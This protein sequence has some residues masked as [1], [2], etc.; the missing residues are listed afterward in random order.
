MP[1]RML[2][3]RP[4]SV[5][6]PGVRS[7]A[8]RSA[9]ATDTSS[10]STSSWFSRPARTPSKTSAQTGT[11]SG[12]ATHEPS[13]PARRL[14]G[15]SSRTLANA[16]SLT[17]GS[18]RLGMNAAIPPIANAPRR[19]QVRTIRSAYAFIIGAAIVTALRSGRVKDG[20]ASRKFLM[21]LNR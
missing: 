12:C 2:P 18:R 9:A 15:L 20:P 19:W 11:R 13:K 3:R 21:M 5:R 10:R 7:T 17:S 1:I 8:S 16:R 6:S 14:T 4:C